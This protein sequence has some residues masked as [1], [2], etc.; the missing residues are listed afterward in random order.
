M[1]HRYT[2][3]QRI[4]GA[5]PD[6]LSGETAADNQPGPNEPVDHAPVGPIGLNS[7]HL[8]SIHNLDCWNPKV[9]MS[10]HDFDSNSTFCLNRHP[11]NSSFPQLSY[12]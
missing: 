11:Y 5:E 3:L 7:G 4:S 8:A 10:N 2:N 1:D 6:H 9:E 12:R